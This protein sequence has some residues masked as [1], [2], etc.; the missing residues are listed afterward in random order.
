M[1]S[2]AAETATLR[3]GSTVSIR[4]IE[5]GDGDRL[6]EI[7][8]AMSELSRRQRFLS[9]PAELSPEDLRYFVDVDHRRH[10]ALL[11][12]DETGRAVAEARYVR[13][14]R[15]R[16]SAEIAV[17]VVD[18]WQRRGLA[19]D[20]LNRLSERARAN[21]IERYTAVVADDNRVVL[22]A[23]ER[24]GAERAA[25]SEPGE[26]ELVVDVPDAHSGDRLAGMLRAAAEFPRDFLGMVLRRVPVWRRS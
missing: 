1:E 13:A 9:A 10:E 6:R 21:G 16:T 17:V 18:D 23:L 14:P 5:P 15:D 7:W 24:A 12:L 22:G 20:L 26:V 8:D 19:T 25:S 4:P 2:T 11:A 3:D